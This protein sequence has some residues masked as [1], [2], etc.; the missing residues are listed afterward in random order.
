[1]LLSD[2]NIHSEMFHIQYVNVQTQSTE[3]ICILLNVNNIKYV[4]I[5]TRK[6]MMTSWMT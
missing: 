5:L 6:Q 3:I 2:D 4:P 1:M